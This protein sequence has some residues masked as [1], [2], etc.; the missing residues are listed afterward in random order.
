M[1]EIYKLS[2]FEH[3]D[4]YV[5]SNKIVS[6]EIIRKKNFS[7]CS[8]RQVDFSNCTFDSTS[9]PC[10]K[11]EYL[12]FKNCIFQSVNFRKYKF[13]YAYSKKL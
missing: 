13:I 12:T 11:C 2:E 5:L 3:G 10:S 4:F 7:E 9:F 6:D 8:I 1:K